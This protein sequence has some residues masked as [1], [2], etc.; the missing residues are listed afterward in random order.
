MQRV[1]SAHA[2]HEGELESLVID[3]RGKKARPTDHP[4]GWE[5]IKNFCGIGELR[6]RGYD[7]TGLPSIVLVLGVAQEK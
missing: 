1:L 4:S 7:V 6:S 3:T 5:G 2:R